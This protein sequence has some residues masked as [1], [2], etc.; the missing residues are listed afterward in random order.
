[1]S[2]RNLYTLLAYVAL[3]SPRLCTMGGGG[4]GGK[5]HS[6]RARPRLSNPTSVAGTQGEGALKSYRVRPWEPIIIYIHLQQ[7]KISND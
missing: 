7:H 2:Q 3:R 5:L 4:G 6:A 1:M